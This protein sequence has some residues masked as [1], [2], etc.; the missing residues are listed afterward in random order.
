M[1]IDP[2]NIGETEPE[3]LFQGEILL[4]VVRG[5]VVFE[6]AGQFR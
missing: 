6:K 2:L 5:N 1:N 3:E 4:T